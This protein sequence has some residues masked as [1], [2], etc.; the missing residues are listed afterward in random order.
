MTDPKAILRAAAVVAAALLPA[1]CAQGGGGQSAA[2]PGHDM[3]GGT[4]MSGMMAHCAEM[5]Q[6]QAQGQRLSP[7]MQGMMAHCDEMDRSMGAMPGMGAPAAPA[8]TRSR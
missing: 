2:A 7:D 4:D 1:A 5:R 6:Q 8:A 3:A